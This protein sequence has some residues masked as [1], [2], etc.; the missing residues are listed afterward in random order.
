M[1]TQSPPLTTAPAAVRS[2]RTLR[3]KLI[4]VAAAAA[5]AGGVALLAGKVVPDSTT[6][7]PTVWSLDARTVAPDRSSHYFSDGIDGTAGTAIVA[8]DDRW[9]ALLVGRDT[10]DGEEPAA[11][12]A[13]TPDSGE[14]AWTLDLPGAICSDRTDEDGSL[15]CLTGTGDDWELSRVD[16]TGGTV[17][18]SVPV[19]ITEPRQVHLADDGLLVVSESAPGVHSQLSLL[20]ADGASRWSADLLQLVGG[21][22]LFREQRTDDGGKEMA[23]A[24]GSVWTDVGDAVLLGK[25]DFVHIRAATEQ[26]QVHQGDA[27]AV[28]DDQ[29]FYS[30]VRGSVGYDADGSKLWIQPDV[31]LVRSADDHPAGRLLHAGETTLHS[32][33]PRTGEPSTAIHD[34]E[35]RMGSVQLSGPADDAYVINRSEVLRLTEDGSG[36]RWTAKLPD[37]NS[38]SQGITLEDTTVVTTS[39]ATGL[40]ASSG[41]ER[42][43]ADVLGSDLTVID[44]RLVERDFRTITVHSLP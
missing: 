3:W 4:A 43:R 22:V 37:A 5:V 15:P 9:I 38:L 12:L 40:D 10:T 8:T 7:L 36:V 42:W 1:G 20:A 31:A 29:F 25:S 14:V 6:T 13:I 17:T 32:V 2:G 39:P 11:L 28:V 21:E 33:D 30:S 44:G 27:L 26:L 18:E 16:L 23:L 34:F 19:D 41:E 35:D 24:S